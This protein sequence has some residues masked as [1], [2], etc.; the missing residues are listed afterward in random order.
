MQGTR[1]RRCWSSTAARSCSPVPAWGLQQQG[2]L[3]DVEC[4]T[5]TLQPSKCTAAD[6]QQGNEARASEDSGDK[7]WEDVVLC[8]G[9]L[10]ART[11]C[12]GQGAKARPPKDSCGRGLWALGCC[13][14]PPVV[15]VDKLLQHYI[16]AA[17][18]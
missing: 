17:L 14:S 15:A 2:E 3:A 12:R 5:C 9:R 13:T 4:L 6:C 8:M 7:G 11:P 18:P 1:L 10:H 16:Q